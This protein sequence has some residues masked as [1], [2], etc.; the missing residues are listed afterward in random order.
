METYNGRR[1][2]Q[3][4]RRA[5][6]PIG[7]Y[8][9]SARYRTRCR[10][11]RI[12]RTGRIYCRPGAVG[13]RAPVAVLGTTP[14][15]HTRSRSR[16]LPD[17]CGRS[18][19][20]AQPRRRSGRICP[21][22]TCRHARAYSTRRWRSTTTRLKQT[23]GFTTRTD[24]P[25]HQRRENTARCYGRDDQKTDRDTEETT[26]RLNYGQLTNFFS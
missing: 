8:H 5:T 22:I 24:R 1:Q 19:S 7:S 4:T 3:S 23:N 6:Y 17:A 13:R 25:Q 12:Y 10:R 26:A 15:A 9:V 11:R 21:T 18:S 2:I 20:M 16:P 14:L